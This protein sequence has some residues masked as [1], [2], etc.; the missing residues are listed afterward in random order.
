[1][2]QENSTRRLKEVQDKLSSLK[3]A[4]GSRADLE[5]QLEKAQQDHKAVK[6]QLTQETDSTNITE[7]QRTKNTLAFEAK[8]AKEKLQRMAE[9]VQVRAQLDVKQKQLE[10]KTGERDALLARN[11]DALESLFGYLPDEDINTEY[12]IKAMSTL[13]CSRY[14]TKLDE[15]RL[16]H[17]ELRQETQKLET[18][19]ASVKSNRGLITSEL[20]EAEKKAEELQRK[21][22][23]AIGD[24]S[25]EEAYTSAEKRTKRRQVY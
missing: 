10:I 15:R 5:H 14:Q 7:L 3:P 9:T 1:M 24:E 17:K 2:R 13:T 20:G 12:A 16:R 25:F 21:V 18:R 4:L 11:G 19:L 6:Q 22:N 23:E 8:N